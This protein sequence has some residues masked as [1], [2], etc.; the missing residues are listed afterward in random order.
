[1][2]TQVEQIELAAIVLHGG[3]APVVGVLKKETDKEITLGFAAS[4]VTDDGEN[5]HLVPVPLA[6]T[7]V[8]HTYGKDATAIIPKSN[9]VVYSKFLV[10]EGTLHPIA[11]MFIEFWGAG[12]I[13]LAPKA[14]QETEP[15]TE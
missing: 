14:E 1:M 15:T 5:F 11:Q 3:T 13:G 4:C 8:H 9:V 12:P 2:D 10:G 6:M 7:L